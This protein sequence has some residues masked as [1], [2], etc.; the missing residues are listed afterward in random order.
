MKYSII[1]MI[2]S[3]F[4]I[5]VCSAGFVTE[6]GN[7]PS[8]FGEYAGLNLSDPI[9]QGWFD[10]DFKSLQ[11]PIN[12]GWF[13]IDIESLI[14]PINPGWFGE[15]ISDYLFPTPGGSDEESFQ[16]EKVPLIKP[17]PISLTKDDLFKSLTTVSE[18]KKTAISSQMKGLYF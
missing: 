9:N 1:L 17:E 13:D 4:F 11:E 6:Q 12:S 10:P 18:T 8:V 3:C 2:L 14:E 16:W 7:S 5:G 15:D